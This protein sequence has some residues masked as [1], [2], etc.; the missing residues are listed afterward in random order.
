MFRLDQHCS[1]IKNAVLNTIQDHKIKTPDIGGTSTTSQFVE[2]VLNEIVRM[3]PQLGFHYD[4]QQATQT[5]R[6]KNID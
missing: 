5:F 6:Y 3:T 1:T 2:C 4:M